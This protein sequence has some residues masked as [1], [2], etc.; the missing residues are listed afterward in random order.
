[1]E[2]KGETVQVVQ[3]GQIIPFDSTECTIGERNGRKFLQYRGGRFKLV[4]KGCRALYGVAAH[5]KYAPKLSLIV[6]NNAIIAAFA[7]LS[8]R[9]RTSYNLGVNNVFKSILIDDEKTGLK[10][11][12]LKVN[13]E[14][15]TDNGTAI[16]GG[17]LPDDI[18]NCLIDT[19]IYHYGQ[20]HGATHKLVALKTS[21]VDYN[22][23]L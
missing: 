20:Y 7:E 1:M 22:D 6:T 9:I 21:R 19:S 8:E 23:V 13:E 11:M 17:V 12:V 4:L 10:K 15:K 3:Y 18:C 2:T 5:S 14:M 16:R